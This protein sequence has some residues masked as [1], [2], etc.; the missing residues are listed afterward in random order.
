VLDGMTR[1]L[2]SVALAAL[3]TTTAFAQTQTHP[4]PYQYN[5]SGIKNA[6]GRSGDASIDGQTL[7][8]RDGDVTLDLS[9][10]GAIDKVQVKMPSGPAT[11]FNGLDGS[12]SFTA[13]LGIVPWH[14]PVSIQANVASAT[15][16]RTEVVDANDV[17]KRR[18]DLRVNSVD[19]P[20]HMLTGFPAII[21][22]SLSELNGETGAHANVRLLANGTEVDRIDGV[23]V[24]AG[25]T[26]AVS[27]A[28]VFESPGSTYL[29]VIVDG[30]NPGDWDDSNN[31]GTAHTDVYSEG[32]PFFSW[33]ATAHEDT[34]TR[35][36]HSLNSYEEN[37]MDSSGTT[38]SFHF[39]A[40]TVPHANLNS[41]NVTAS[42]ESDGVS[43]IPE[44]TATDWGLSSTPFSRCSHSTGGGVE[45][46]V[47]NSVPGRFY[48]GDRSVVTIDLGNSAI[49]YHS[50]GYNKDVIDPS[51]PTGYATVDV[52]YIA[53]NTVTPIGNTATLHVMLSDG[54][55]LWKADPFFGSF[56]TTYT[57]FD[58]PWQC[59]NNPFVGMSCGENHVHGVARDATIYNQ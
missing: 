18:P 22:V 45:A 15:G 58:Q 19:A 40:I 52:T 24:D 39:T 55:T 35:S 10:N 21:R 20:V 49:S 41:L 14:T 11:N 38:Q 16:A 31:S 57:N 50:W 33:N 34:T 13:S 3:L 17:V 6:T 56:T 5:N 1:T 4:L 28:T 44:R 43:V 47:C 30:V 9:A 59:S 27:L 42:A 7:L 8:G 48:Q 23:W 25:D 54:T 32:D 26:V 29:Q 37:H 12:N 51:S 53:P 46:S 2:S 36:T